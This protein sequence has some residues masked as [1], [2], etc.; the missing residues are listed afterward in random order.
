MNF[1]NLKTSGG[2]ILE[3]PIL[4]TPQIYSDERGFF[5]ESWNK[6]IFNEFVGREINFVQDN[7]SCSKK[8]VLRGLHYQKKPKA[9]GKLV[10]C[11]SGSIFDVIVD[12]RV[13]SKNYK[14]YVGIQLSSQ[15]K[16]I[17]WVP[18]G[19][20]HGFLSLSQNVEVQYKVNEYWDK[21]LERSIIWNDELINISWPLG[22]DIAKPILNKKDES[23]Q[24]LAKAMELGDLF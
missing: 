1:S 23:A 2:K 13:A 24:T 8:G 3:G 7:H 17:L 11:I 18:E 4:I 21:E 22:N 9:Q 5:Y 14:E 20:G 19:F 6:K 16:Q 12:L 15:T 10:R